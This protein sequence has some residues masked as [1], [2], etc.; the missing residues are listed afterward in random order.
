MRISPMN[1]RS[2]LTHTA[3]TIAGSAIA[4]HA[5]AQQPAT[6]PPTPQAATAARQP[7]PLP[8]PANGLEHVEI[9][10]QPGHYG[11]WPANHGIWIWRNELLVGFSDG[12]LKVGDPERHPIDR[13]QPE[14]HQLARSSDGGW[15]WAIEQHQELV[16]PPTPGHMSDVPTEKGGLMPS[17]LK[18]S[19]DFSAPGF[20][21]SLRMADKDTGPSWFFATNNR[22]R[23][24]T[25]PYALPDFGTPGI[26]A[27]TDYVVMGPQ[28]LVAFVTAAKPDGN[29]GR[30]LSIE[31]RDG[32]LT[33]QMLG[34]IGPQTAG[35][36]IMPTTVKLAD[37]RFY[38][39]IRTREGQRHSLDAFVSADA[40]R[41]WTAL[42]TPVA[43]AGRGNP[44]ALL[45]L[46]DG[47]LAL[48][49]GH[50]AKPY[51]I[52]A[53]LSGDDGRTWGAPI[54]LRDDAA[55]WDLGYPRAVQ[56]P[57]DVIVTAY[58]YNDGRSP[59]RYIA[60][61]LWKP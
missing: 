14:R 48:I 32:G 52:R 16:P 4:P 59:E 35:W 47:R 10:R 40:G 28:H 5:F 24:W 15:H 29:E 56:R 60:A 57:D 61:T 45:L 13:Q 31:T 8:Q 17:P 58:Y 21:M 33:W 55:D 22:G 34:W 39:V 44:G 54:T 42:G 27:R 30:P 26:T 9:W 18:D 23:L 49:Y 7:R 41:T 51:G 36:R 25:G 43:D 11:G 12:R 38:S 37:G 6:P 2:F 20:A 3:A 19:L 53:V 46:A 50:R 1:R